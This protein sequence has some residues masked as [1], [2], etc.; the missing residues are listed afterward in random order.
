MRNLTVF[1]SLALIFVVMSLGFCAVSAVLIWRLQDAI[2]QERIN[3]ARDMS[4]AAV[5]IAKAFDDEVKAGHLSLA[6]AQ[7]LA[8]TAIRGLRWDGPAGYLAA[9][10]WDGVTIVHKNPKYEGVNRYNAVDST[11]KHTVANI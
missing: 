3:K 5:G 2:L 9:Y 7:A 8:K 6:D 11:G 10:Q 1:R 4:T